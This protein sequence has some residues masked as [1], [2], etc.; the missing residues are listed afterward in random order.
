MTATTPAA[1]I[2]EPHLRDAEQ[3][4]HALGT[5]AEDGL[6]PEEAARRL[7]RSGPNRIGRARQRSRLGMLVDQFRSVVILVLLAAVGAAALLGEVVEAAA[8]GAV[9][10]VNTAIGFVTELRAQHA[11]EQLQ[12]ETAARARVIRGGADAVVD[13]EQ[14]VPGD[15]VVLEAGDVVPADLRIVREEGL[16]VDEAPLTGESEGVAKDPAAVSGDVPLADRVN[17]AFRGT[18]VQDGRGEA[19]VVATGAATEI[20]KIGTLVETVEDTGSPLQRQLDRLGRVLVV[21]VVVLGVLVAVLGVARGLPVREVVEVAIALGIAAV[22]EGLPAVTTLTLALGML[23]MARR[24]ALVRTLP[25]VEALGST[26]VICTDKTGTLTAGQMTVQ[27]YHLPGGPDITVDGAGYEPSGEF[28]ADDSRLDVALRIGVLCGD[29]VLKHDDGRWAV[30]GDPTEGALVVAGAK[31][32]LDAGRLRRET[33][34]IWRVPFT[35]ERQWMATFHRDVPE[36]AGP[37]AY[38]KGAPR[39]FIDAATRLV[40]PHG[41]VRDLTERDRE[42]LRGANAE[43]ADRGLRV[44]GLA[45]RAAEPPGEDAGGDWLADLVLVGLVGMAD[46]PHHRSRA[47]SASATRRGSASRCSPATSPPPPR[48]SHAIWNWTRTGGSARCIPASCAPTVH[49]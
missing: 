39:R 36:G 1:G 9:V 20:G 5:D 6:S 30:L 45:W 27:R 10:V 19:I 44:L 35:S 2:G 16:V 49:R 37:I 25:S 4:V 42:Q 32:G 14:L 7:E 47:R 46:P 18:T 33:L 34:D 26:T 3:V 43:L 38:L 29:A 28:S 15:L 22:P 12:S 13:V 31:R 21:V 8:I 24:N 23:A 48:R 40:G 11:L 17:S 41:E